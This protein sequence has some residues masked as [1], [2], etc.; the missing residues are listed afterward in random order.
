MV[1]DELTLVHYFIQL[2]AYL[3]ILLQ[4]VF[5][6]IENSDPFRAL[7]FDRLHV[8]QGGLWSDHFWPELQG[9]ISDLGRY[10]KK[11]VDELQVSDHSAASPR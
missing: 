5:W 8:N 2:E 11:D 7:S 3:K 4:N 1:F 10:A 9:R 6:D